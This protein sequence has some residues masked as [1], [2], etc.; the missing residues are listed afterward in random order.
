MFRRKTLERIRTG[1]TTRL[2]GKNFDYTLIQSS[3]ARTVRFKVSLKNG[4]EVVVPRR[5]SVSHLEE[6]IAEHEQW[7]IRQ[8]TRLESRKKLQKTQELR[9]GSTI[10]LLGIPHRIKI[11]ENS[12][13]KPFVK[14]V[15]N[16]TFEQDVAVPG[17]A[18]LHVYCAGTMKEVK[19]TLEKYL[20]RVA[21]KYFL[22]RTATLAGQ[23]G[24]SFS[25]ITIR[26]QK[27]RW[28]SCTIEKNLNFNWRLVLLPLAVTE[29]VIIHEL[30]HTVHM[31]HSGAFYGLV[32]AH[33]PDYRKLQKHLHNPRFPV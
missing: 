10:M 29:S 3:M 32:E 11:I 23:M 14:R 8:F 4:L 17:N 27:T 15:Q 21:E 25:K 13:K 20:R 9:D 22:R 12:K 16:L 1:R 26:A 2:N 30:A 28:G 18:E 6:I 33:C 7:I 5:F 19:K 31:N 24:V